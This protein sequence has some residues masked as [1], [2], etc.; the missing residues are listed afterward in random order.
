MNA[1]CLTPVNPQ[2]MLRNSDGFQND[3]MI[4]KVKGK[5]DLISL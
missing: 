4:K 5:E 3:L 1:N 2:F